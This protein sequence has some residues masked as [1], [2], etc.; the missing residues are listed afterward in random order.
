[1]TAKIKQI[2]NN[3]HRYNAEHIAAMTFGFSED[4]VYDALIVAPSY[5][6]YKLNADS[7]FTIKE[8]GRKLPGL[9]PPPAAATCSTTC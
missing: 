1:M 2:L 8:T 6:P 5:S 9:R 3:M 7:R 4:I